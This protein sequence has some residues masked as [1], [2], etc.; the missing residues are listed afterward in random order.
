MP[1]LTSISFS[2]SHEYKPCDRAEVAN[3]KWGVRPE[4]PYGVPDGQP[5]ER[6]SPLALGRF[7]VGWRLCRVRSWASAH[8]VRFLALRG[9]AEKIAPGVR[10]SRFLV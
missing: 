6:D 3:E 5:F 10:A 4:R 7:V 1:S 2:P 8:L 9:A